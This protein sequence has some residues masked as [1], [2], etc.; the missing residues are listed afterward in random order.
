VS[1]RFDMLLIYRDGGKFFDALQEQASRDEYGTVLGRL[2]CFYVR[3]LSLQDEIEPDECVT[4]YERHLLKQIQVSRLCRLMYLLDLPSEEVIDSDL[5]EAFHE[6]IQELFCWTESKKLLEEVEC[7]VQRFLMVACLRKEGKG[8]IHVRDITP[9]IAKLMYCIRASVFTELIKRE[10]QELRLE[11]ELDGLQRYVKDLVQSP[12]GFL[13]ETMHLAATVAGY[14]SALPQVVW[15]GE[16]YKSLT[17]HGKRVDLDELQRLCHELLKDAKRKVRHEIRMGLPGFK[18]FNWDRFDPEDDLSNVDLNYSF[19]LKAFAGKR[20]ALLDQFLDN[21]VTNDYFTK[22][23][24]G[25]RILWN[26]KN[27]INWMKKCKQLLEIL[28]TACHLLGGQPARST[29][30]VTIRW[31]N[32][33]DEQRGVYWAYGTVVLLGQYS[34]TRSQSSQNRLIPRYMGRQRSRL[35][36]GRFLPPEL[37]T[38]VTEYLAMIRPIEI[39]F[40]GLFNC[41]GR[42]DLNEFLW[43][44]YKKGIWSGEYL[45]DLLKS[46][47]SKS[48]MRALGFRDYRQIAVAFMEKHLKHN[49]GGHVWEGEENIFDLQAGHVGRTVERHYA[50]A[51]G[52]SRIVSREGMHQYYHA[53]KAW[54]ELLL[55]MERERI[56]QG[57]FV[58]WDYVN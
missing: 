52:D 40:S 48:K 58:V 39:F 50:V 53:S 36:D 14:G 2:V 33:A 24:V 13:C 22:G 23:R 18:D 37:G 38:L 43:A 4:W 54:Y 3:L 47:T 42:N 29:E 7:P 34:K 28:A 27:C 17:I 20:K 26:K 45:S 57:I 31:K 46:H 6:T 51:S 30:L 11:D 56:P 41:K 49:L 10:G 19:I 44:D 15:L 5:D 1:F 35:T 16:E 12:F 55:K 25:N 21:K 8:F 9:L 32:S